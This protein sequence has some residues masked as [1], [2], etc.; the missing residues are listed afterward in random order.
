MKS[1]G[2]AAETASF[3]PSVIGAVLR[4]RTLVAAI[5][6]ASVLLGTLYVTTRPVRY[7]ATSSLVVQDPRGTG[8]FDAQPTMEASRYAANQVA[9]L[10]QRRVAEAAYE[11]L[12]DDDVP[13][14][15]SFEEFESEITVSSA[16]EENN[17]IEVTATTDDPASAQAAA[18]AVVDAY[19]EVRRA[20]ASTNTVSALAQLEQLTASIDAELDTI[21]GALANEATPESQLEGLGLQQAALIERRSDLSSRRE[22]LLF[23]TE[24]D[25]AGI[26]A[27][28]PATDAFMRA[29]GRL[30]TLVLAVALGGLLGAG[31]AYSLA[32]RRRRFSNRYQPELVLDTPLLADVPV[33][34]SSDEELPV[35]VSPVSAAAEAFRFAASSM[36]IQVVSGPGT[37]VTAVSPN[38]GDGKSV[39][40]A[41]TALALAHSGASVLVIDADG[42]RQ[43]VT[44]IYGDTAG[45]PGL[46]DIM[47]GEFQ[48]DAVVRHVLDKSIAELDLLPFGLRRAEA[49]AL[50]S[51]NSILDAVLDEARQRYNFVVVDVPPLPRSALAA[52]MLSR[53]D[54]AFVVVGHDSL[55]AEHEE[56]AERLR[57]I[58]TPCLGYVYNRAPIRSQ[59]LTAY[60]EERPGRRP[61]KTLSVG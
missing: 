3:E 24:L 60:G 25:T 41:N 44:R 15:M 31:L 8:L 11:L 30:R 10:R 6:L 19:K 7:S 55:V 39:V 35:L 1:N 53:S 42:E 56:I 23:D 40:V 58:S 57:F 14:D 34:A 20:E 27:S 47:S 18:N 29:S 32:I 38:S 43:D 45:L 12:Q 26:E 13:L 52:T 28:S 16:V 54:R 49:S 48:L 61:G 50:S 51:Q 22:E 37:V 4:Y 9:I 21:A 59:W 5:V 36:Q 2:P 33:F 46:T 17:L